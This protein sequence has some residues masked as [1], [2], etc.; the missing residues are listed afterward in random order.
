MRAIIDT[1]I[2]FVRVSSHSL[3]FGSRLNVI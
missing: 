3:C 2:F 1:V